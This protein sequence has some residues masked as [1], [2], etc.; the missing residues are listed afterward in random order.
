MVISPDNGLISSSFLGK[1]VFIAIL[2]QNSIE[3]GKRLLKLNVPLT[4]PS[5]EVNVVRNN[6]RGRATQ[7]II[8]L[9]NLTACSPNV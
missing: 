1:I 6:Q 7:G 3:S 2:S 9:C 5:R 8:L 4:L